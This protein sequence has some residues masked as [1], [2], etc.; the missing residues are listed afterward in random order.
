[1]AAEFPAAILLV[2]ADVHHTIMCIMTSA[3]ADFKDPEDCH[4]ILRLMRCD[5]NQWT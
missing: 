5:Q 3:L 1:M 2:L 4:Q